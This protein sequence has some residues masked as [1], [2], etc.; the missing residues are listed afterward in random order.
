MSMGVQSVAAPVAVTRLDGAST[1]GE[2]R[3]FAPSASAPSVSNYFS[4]SGL[5]SRATG[6]LLLIPGLPITALLVVLVRLTSKG[7]G[8][9]HQVRVG[10]NGQDFTMYKIRTMRSD[11]EAATGAV[12]C[13][14]RDPRITR[15]GNVLRLLH[16][17]ELP[18][19]WNMARGEMCLIGPRPERPE[20]TQVLEELVP[21]YTDRLL[22][23]PGITGLAQINLPPDSDLNS[24]RRKLVLDREYIETASLSMD[25]RI[26]MRTLF[27][28]LNIHGDWPSQMLGI[29]RT[30]TLAPELEAI[31]Q[32]IEAAMAEH[33]AAR[34][35]A[36]MNGFSQNG[37]GKASHNGH[38]GKANGVHQPTAN[39]QAHA[40]KLAA[41]KG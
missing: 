12:W 34:N 20:F 35:G 9:Y 24:V 25:F 22:V 26:A 19:L 39:G 13:S 31:S 17:D 15:V 10:L 21:G 30:V 18:Q 27:R 23:K 11:A 36:A 40:P 32:P 3:P 29:F 1:Y 2:V 4:W 8:I 37:H 41:R 14:K 5:L 38:T 16:L 28:L 33:S 7:P 6:W